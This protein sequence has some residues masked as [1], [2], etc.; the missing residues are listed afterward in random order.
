MK[1]EKGLSMIELVMAMLMLSIVMLGASSLESSVARIQSGTIRSVELQNNLSYA[2][3]QLDQDL[4]N[5][6]RVMIDRL[7]DANTPNMDQLFEWRI[8]PL[9]GNTNGTDDISYVL[10]LRANNNFFR[11]TA[12]NSTKDLLP[13]GTVTFGSL[14]H[15]NVNS[16]IGMWASADLKLLTLNLNLKVEASQPTAASKKPGYQKSFLIRTA[17]VQDCRSAACP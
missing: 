10:D 15:P 2:Y 3:R 12:Q 7:P 17:V 8:R 4:G 11:R 13:S 6:S 9:N 16:Q 1:N 5:A 14:R